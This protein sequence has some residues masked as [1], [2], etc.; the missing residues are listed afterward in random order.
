[1]MDFLGSGL[2][3]LPQLTET[4]SRSPGV[5]RRLR[6]AFQEVMRMVYEMWG[7]LGIEDGTSAENTRG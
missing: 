3:T 4:R 1:M 5:P 2:K 7:A 6:M